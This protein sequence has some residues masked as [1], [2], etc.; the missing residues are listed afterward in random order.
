[1]GENDKLV[2]VI[3][4][5]GGS[6][7]DTL[8]GLAGKHF[9]VRNVSSITPIKEIAL[10]NG[11]D[12]Q[13]DERSRKFLSDLKKLF[14]EYNDLPNRYLMRQYREF[15]EGDEEILFVHIREAEEIRKFK[16]YV[17]GGCVTLLIHRST[18]EEHPLGNDSDDRVEEYAYDASFDNNVSLEEAEEQFVSLL[19][20]L[21]HAKR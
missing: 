16:D 13:K 2:V 21:M 3:N 9:R 4:G 20:G 19:K 18:G 17:D 5:R 11:W 1:M 14:S 15:L 12:G 6:G 7:K 10:A 8:C